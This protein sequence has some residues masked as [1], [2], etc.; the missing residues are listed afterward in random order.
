MLGVSSAS[1]SPLLPE[2]PTIAQ[3][4][5]PG[6]EANPS[7]DV[8]A[9]AGTPSAIVAKVSKEIAT[10]LHE[11]EARQRLEGLGMEIATDT[12]EQFGVYMRDQSVKWARLIRDARIVAT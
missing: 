9:P 11:G 1:G 5:I 12:P 8:F 2:V 7:F 6:F 3:A 10:I 4:S